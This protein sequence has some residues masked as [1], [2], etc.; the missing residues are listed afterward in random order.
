MPS[1]ISWGC[2][3]CTLITHWGDWIKIY[4]TNTQ[5]ILGFITSTYSIWEAQKLKPLVYFLL[6]FL[7][8]TP[9]QISIRLC[10]FHK[11]NLIWMKG[12]NMGE[13]WWFNGSGKWQKLTWSLLT[14]SE[15]ALGSLDRKWHPALHVC[16]NH[17][18][19]PLCRDLLSWNGPWALPWLPLS[20]VLKYC[21]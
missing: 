3:T 12:K 20:V 18:F 14:Y 10:N 4:S 11:K 5:W 17:L 1:M 21:P 9:L 2:L 6:S 19:Q 7:I 16:N 8:F 13:T 15:R